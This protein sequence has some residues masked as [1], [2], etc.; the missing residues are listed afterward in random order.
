M[1]L[2]LILDIA[3]GLIFIY[4]I[5]SLLASE[6]QELLSAVLQW[7]AE[8]LKKSI[9]VLLSGQSQDGSE[10]Q[11]F[12]DSLYR[13]PLIK[14]LNQEA[15][16]PIANFFRRVSHRIGDLYH[17]VTRTE[18][19]FGEQRSGPSYIPSQSFAAALMQ[20]LNIEDLSQKISELTL[21]KFGEEKLALMQEILHDLRNSLADDS[22]LEKEFI[23]LK[24]SLNEIIVDFV[25]RRTT[26][27][28]S[29][30]Q[31]AEQ[32]I[33]FIENTEAMIADNHHCKDIV[34][35]RLPYLKQVILL[36][37]L[38]PTISEVLSV[39]IDRD[40]YRN[41]PPEL[42]AIVAKI[43]RENP[44]LPEQLKRNLSAL[45]KQA[46]TK[47]R[48]LEEGVQELEKEMSLWFDRSME[49]A[50]G[51]YKRNAK[52]V[53]LIIGFCIA[54]AANA[55]TFH[56]VSRL[57]RDSVLRNTIAQAAD[58]VIV[59]TIQPIEPAVE[60]PEEEAAILPGESEAE[61]QQELETLRD[62]VNSTLEG[63]PLPIGWNEVNVG[64]Q[65]LEAR[66]WPLPILRRI[67]GWLITAIA[68]SMG[69]A[70]WFGLLD[71]VMKV[72]STGKP[73]DGAAEQQSD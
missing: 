28:A 54:F 8:H 61:I 63:L 55:D 66:H 4:L 36:G 40:N 9:E 38:E 45:A 13:S 21:R 10:V 42:D 51:V 6:I 22:I 58:Q 68:I 33:R 60:G 59:Q 3:I 71:K 23:T 53:A 52:G 19:I 50:S 57:S 31:A 64:Q 25:N 49:R 44:G 14:A 46:Q 5:L 29:I 69:S 18:N 56:I 65:V 43:H 11:R 41:L 39:V 73:R 20:K 70:F 15:K 30:D 72:R 26:F 16:G 62:A 35:G 2:P 34:R 32:L 12:A 17:A 47:A 24:H 48:N 1:N 27:S 7:R 37:K 67:L